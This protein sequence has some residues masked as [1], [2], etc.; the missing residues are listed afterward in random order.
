MIQLLE[1]VVSRLSWNEST[2]LGFP[3]SL[4][5]LRR[6]PLPKSRSLPST[7]KAPTSAAP[8]ARIPW[9]ATVTT[10]TPGSTRTTRSRRLIGSTSSRRAARPWSTM[11]TIA[12]GNMSD[13][14]PLLGAEMSPATAMITGGLK[15]GPA[16]L[17]RRRWKIL[18]AAFATSRPHLQAAQGHHF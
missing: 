6:F 14:V 9:S 2:A 11:T 13:L 8:I 18:L 4:A 7:A 15:L 3:P 1:L 16:P 10:A 17:R 12:T 5:D